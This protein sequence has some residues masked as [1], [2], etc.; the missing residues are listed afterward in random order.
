MRFPRVLFTVRRAMF[1]IAAVAL[2]L[3]GS[4]E[5]IRLKRQREEFLKIAAAHGMDEAIYLI[6]E[7]GAADM[8]EIAEAYPAQMKEIRRSFPIP[9][10]PRTHGE[11]FK[12]L[13]QRRAS[14]EE[15]RS[16]DAERQKAI[17]A[18]HREEAAKYAEFAAYHTALSANTS[19]P[20]RIPGCLSSRTPRLLTP[21]VEDVSGPSA[22][23]TLVLGP[24]TRRP[25]RLTIQICRCSTNS[26]G[27]WPPARTQTFVMDGGP[28]NWRRMRVNYPNGL[29]RTILIRWLRLMPR[30]GISRPP[31]SRR[32]KPLGIFPWENRYRGNFRID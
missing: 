22:V 32:T 25:L 23:S 18:K 24:H 12:K 8:A 6:R 16:K 5:A 20:V 30:P 3:G 15:Q 17:A 7:G 27:P 28:L 11:V 19:E 10:L 1:A 31:S 13:N 14:I 26:H 9:P 2:V 4:V 21:R 29:S